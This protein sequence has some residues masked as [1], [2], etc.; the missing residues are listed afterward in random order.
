LRL[1]KPIRH[2]IPDPDRAATFDDKD[3]AGHFFGQDAG[4][5]PA[6]IN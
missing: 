4:T 6:P 5:V 2:K 1:V 3:A